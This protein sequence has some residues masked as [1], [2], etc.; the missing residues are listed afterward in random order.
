MISSGYLLDV[1]L[2]IDFTRPWTKSAENQ[3]IA[4]EVKN[5]DTMRAHLEENGVE[6]RE[7]AVIPG[8]QRLYVLDPFGNYFEFIEM[9]NS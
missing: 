2:R 1:L 3:L 9:N 5:L 8:R 7:A 4:V 6:T